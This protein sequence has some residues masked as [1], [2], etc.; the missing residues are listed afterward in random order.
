MSCTDIPNRAG[1]DRFLVNVLFG[2]LESGISPEI[3]CLSRA[4][5]AW[6]QVLG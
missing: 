4:D 5:G 1:G 6:R 2:G 3:R